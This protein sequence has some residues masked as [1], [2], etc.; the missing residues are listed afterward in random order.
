MFN[1][2]PDEIILNIL[3]Y[4]SFNINLYISNKHIKEL[5]DELIDSYIDNIEEIIITLNE[6][7][8]ELINKILRSPRLNLIKLFNHKNKINYVIL[9]FIISFIDVNYLINSRKDV[10]LVTKLL[11]YCK[12]YGL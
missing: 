3:N 7:H 10:V 5:Y 1:T 11:N 6:N 8:I 12:I 4:C 9:V 2:L